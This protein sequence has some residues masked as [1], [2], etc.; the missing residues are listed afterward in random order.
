MARPTSFA[1]GGGDTPRSALSLLGRR[2]TLVTFAVLVGLAALAWALTVRNAQSMSGMVMGLGQVETRMPIDLT[3]P[4]FMAMWLTM[5]VAMMFPTVGPIVLAHRA[6]TARR[7]EGGV[8]TIAFVLG[9]LVVW[10]LVGLVPLGVLLAVR[11]VPPEAARSGW[12]PA[13]AGAVLIV[14]GLYQFTPL[15]RICLR[16]CRSPLGFILSHDFG[17]GA[18]G[19][20]RAGLS[21]GAYCLGCCWA[22]MS[23]LVVVGV[24][25]LVWMAILAL[26]F[27]AEKSWRHGVGL[28]RVAGTAVALLGLAILLHPDLLTAV[29]GPGASGMGSGTG[30]G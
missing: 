11:E 1:V 10:T 16:A 8:P 14:A 25:N 30:S 2:P 7:G 22:L 17:S 3:V 28:S 9:Y 26:I 23:V 13:V 19:A 24:M 18:V 20:F 15:K 6:V 4:L 21:H 27:L 12:L 5:M 29:S